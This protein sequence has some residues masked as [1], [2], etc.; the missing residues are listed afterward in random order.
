MGELID[1]LVRQWPDNYWT[2]ATAGTSQIL[3]TSGCVLDYPLEAER[4]RLPQGLSA[5]GYAVRASAAIAAIF[6]AIK[7]AGRY[8]HDGALT[9]D[10]RTPSNAVKRHF[11]AKPEKIMAIDVE[12]DPAESTWLV[13]L[14]RK[15]YWRLVC[16]RHSPV[17]G[18]T[19]TGAS[20]T[21]LIQPDVT[22]VGSLEFSPGPD[23]KFEGLMAGFTAAIP[24]LE[25]AGLLKGERA[26]KGCLISR[27]FAQIK[28]SS[29]RPGELAQRTAALLAA[30]GLY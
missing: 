7:F 28:R 23:E 3:F 9:V 15:I 1:S 13:R 10:G 20:G 24:P 6:D 5:P 14:F 21:I 30:H 27:E 18:K 4:K 26:N 22:S 29:R 19:L 25:K 17:E 2:G 16:G 8:L 11:G 12:D